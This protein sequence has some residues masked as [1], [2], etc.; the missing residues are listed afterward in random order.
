MKHLLLTFFALLSLT[1]AAQT[2]TTQATTYL[3]G[4][5]SYQAAIE[6]MPEYATVQ[7]QMKELSDKYEAEAK[8]NE[9]EFNQK[10]EDFIAGQR[11]FP[12][13]ILEK[14]Q[15]EL[16][17]LMAKNTTFRDESRRLLAEAEKDA[18]APLQDKLS[19]ILKVVGDREGFA[20]ILNT[21]NNACPYVNK[22]KGKDINQL[23]KDCLK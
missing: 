16:E 3:F 7:K 2:T 14:R 8:R 1:A 9:K 5:L 6:A 13:T 17:E 20:F 23:V 21:D 10:Y 22:S 12:Q 19:K 11:D 18:Y 15:S 4:Y